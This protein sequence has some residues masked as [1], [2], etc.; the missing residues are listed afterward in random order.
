MV[1]KGE[2]PH[3]VEV[4]KRALHGVVEQ[5]RTLHLQLR[6]ELDHRQPSTAGVH[7]RVD[8]LWCEAVA[9]VVG[10]M[11]DGLTLRIRVELHL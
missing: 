9:V 8:D 4:A 7:Q 6:S 5:L 10:V 2:D 11:V 1:I 3:G